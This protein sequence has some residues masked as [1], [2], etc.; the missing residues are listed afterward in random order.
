MPNN[1]PFKINRHL[2]PAL[3]LRRHRGRAGGHGATNDFGESGSLSF[4]DGV[5]TDK[6]ATGSKTATFLRE[7][8]PAKIEVRHGYLVSQ[9]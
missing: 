9:I 6:L 5:A 8:P 2:G 7:R 3:S 4:L 1:V